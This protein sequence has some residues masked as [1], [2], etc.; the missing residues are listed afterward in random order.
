VPES[1]ATRVLVVEDDPT[2]SE[3]VARY[4]TREG[5]AVEEVADGTHAVERALH[6]LPDL[7]VVDLMIP[8]L[9]GL[10]VCRRLRLAA[11][12]PVIMLTAKSEEADRIAGLELGADDYVSK[13][14]SPRELM[15][16]IRSVLRRARGDPWPQPA[17]VP[18][19][20]PVAGEP[21]AGGAV[22]GG[23]ASAGTASTASSPSGAVLTAGLISVDL[24]AHETRLAGRLVALT[25]K[26]F[27]LLVFLMRNPRQAFSREELLERVWGY[28]Y[29]DTSTVTVHIRRLREKVEADPADPRHVVTVW[30]VGYRFE[31]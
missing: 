23:P 5:Y 27:D 6:S 2:V 18:S 15:A 25:A 7:V 1:A 20:G 10:E 11:P 31:Q 21:V 14:F 24:A 19:A 17:A 29:G 13:P 3:V 28:T 4:L 22:P 16:R 26:E 30:S 9:D 12:I 8:G